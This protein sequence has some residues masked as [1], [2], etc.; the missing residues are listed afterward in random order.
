MRASKWDR[1][2]TEILGFKSELEALVKKMSRPGGGG[3][4]GQ[5]FSAEQMDH[6][7]AFLAF[8]RDPESEK[9]RADLQAM[10]T[11]AVTTTTGATGGYAVPEIISQ[12]IEKN[13][14]EIS[15]LAN[16]VDNQTAG[17]KDFKVLVDVGGASYGWVGEGDAR[18][19]TDTDGLEEAIPTFGTIYAKPK[20]SEESLS[21]IFYDVESWI[22]DSAQDGLSEGVENA[23]VSG[24][25][26]K[27]PT[28]I[29][30]GT[31]TAEVDGTRAYG[32]LQYRPTGLA[33]GFAAENP[34]DVL[35]K[36]ITDLKK[37]YR[38][39]ARWLMNKATVGDVMLFKDGQGNYLW[40]PSAQLGQ[41]DR[42]KG[43]EVIESEEMPDVAAD[44]FPIAFGDYKAGYLLVPLVGL[45]IT[46][47]EITEPGY[48]KWYVRK[49][50]G[51]QYQE[52]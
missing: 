8:M 50:V 13:L 49:R 29:L 51:R 41:P 34:A 28:G 44:A 37:G 7:A 39:N 6:K 12:T 16:Y 31:P 33:G 35:V 5:E 9:A 47:D 20:A 45:R 11:K 10:E 18:P 40:Q 30:S 27:K 19:E 43:Y 1:I 24:N 52:V 46:R 26:T 22:I 36:I 14:L 17:S 48:I 21:D 4:R 25:G 3:E 2:K 23:I 38:R 32:T 42:L 15:D